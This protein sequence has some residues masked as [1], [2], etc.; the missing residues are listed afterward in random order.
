MVPPAPERPTILS[1]LGAQERWLPGVA[2]LLWWVTFHPGFISEDSLV[3]LTDARSGAIS[4]W[5]TAWWI[6]VV[7][8]LTL[9]TRAISLLTLLSVVGLEYAV[10]FWIVTVFPKNSARAVTVL[11]IAL[12][13]IVGAMGIQI[14]HDAALTSGLLICAVVLIRT[15]T[16]GLGLRDYAWLL[17]AMPLIATRHNGVPTIAAAAVFVLMTG[18]RHWRQATTL[19]AV[20]AGAA[21]ITF[22]AT[23]ASGNAN[24][25]DPIQ[26]VEW[27]MGDISC[28][29]GRGRVEATEG[30]WATLTRIAGRDQWPQLRACRV[31]N[32]ILIERLANERAIVENYGEL[33]GVWRSLVARDP[34]EMIAAHASRVRLFLP[35]VPPLEIPTFIHSTIVPNDFGLGWTFPAVAERARV[36]VRAWNALGLV[37]ANSAVWLLV[38]IV[39]AWRMPT[40]RSQLAPTVVIALA[41]NLGLL[42]AA[43]ISEGRYGLFILICGQATALYA[44]LKSKTLA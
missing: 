12:S 8:L 33:I 21:V 14:R 13:P 23:K 2:G 27:L 40:L 26:T 42:A 39:V 11:L 35:P 28:A 18:R 6:Y 10:Y 19:M 29:L 43:P 7:D 5:F 9:G 22:A 41:L 17:L 4:V 38:L 31:M 30:E 15:A 37:L 24:A 34:L 20:A 3:N 25:A 1:W 44:G 32:P 36:V 16:V